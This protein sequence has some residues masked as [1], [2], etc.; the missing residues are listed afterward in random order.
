[1]G[2]Q[3]PVGPLAGLTIEPNSRSI[4]NLVD[5]TGSVDWF[6]TC[7]DGKKVIGGGAQLTSAANTTY[8]DRYLFGTYP[9]SVNTWA[10]NALYVNLTG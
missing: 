7:L 5:A 2:P 1:M 10:A 6:A 4:S 8:E 3:G 9:S